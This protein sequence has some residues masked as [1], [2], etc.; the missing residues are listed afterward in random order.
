M[1]I[2]KY[3]LLASIILISAVANAQS[4]FKPLPAYKASNKFARLSFSTTTSMPDSTF[5]GFRPVVSAA[6]YGYTKAQGSALFTGAGISY[7]WDQWNASTQK[8]YTNY[9]IGAL[10]YAGGTS[11]PTG[12]SGV[13][14]AGLNVSF[15]NK[16]LSIGCAY[17]FQTQT[18]MPTIGASISLNN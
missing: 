13:I 7:E 8:W 15:F 1:V 4:F 17:N 10:F 3:L 14:A 6:V 16:L 9:S 2:M 18:L 12:L 5:T 11:A